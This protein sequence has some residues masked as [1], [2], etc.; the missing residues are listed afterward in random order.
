MNP[1]AMAGDAAL[2]TESIGPSS[3]IHMAVVLT[4]IGLAPAIVLTCTCFARFAI[5]FSFLKAGLGGAGG[6]PSQVL[7]GLSLFMTMF[8]MA[9]VGLRV[10][11]AAISPYL[12]GKIDEKQ[13]LEAATPHIR[14]FLLRHTRDADVALFY[15]VS[16]LARPSSPDD[17]PLQIAVPAF[18]VSELRTAFQMGFLLLLPFLVIDLVVATVLSS[19]GMVMLPPTVISLPVKL[20][21]FITVDGWHLVVRSLLQGAMS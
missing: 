19:M 8:V 15:D 11:E 7:V 6:P 1:L 16:D 4:L 21:V 2:R 17:V 13:A 3:A 18:A 9:P 20:L 10:D 5:V 14:A 12:A